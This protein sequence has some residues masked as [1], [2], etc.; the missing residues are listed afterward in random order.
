MAR[1]LEDEQA[2]AVAWQAG[3]RRTPR[4]RASG[5]PDTHVGWNRLLVG[6]ERRFH[7]G[8][9]IPSLASRSSAPGG[10]QLLHVF[11]ARWLRRDQRSSWVR[12]SETLDA[13]VTYL[14]DYY[15]DLEE[16][17]LWSARQLIERPALHSWFWAPVRRHG[18]RMPGC[19]GLYLASSS[20]ESDAGPV[21][22]AAHAGLEAA[23][24]IRA[25]G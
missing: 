5:R 13:A 7:G 24:A 23:A 20:F 18:I 9:Q 3:L 19:D 25:D 21:D 14:H 11:I 17:I 8:F 22:I 6:P 15:A 2:E 10:G 4:I 12:A 1:A 16:C